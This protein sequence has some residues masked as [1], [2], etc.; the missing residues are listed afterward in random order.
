MKFSERVGAQVV[1]RQIQLEGID[2]ALRNSLW[3]EILQRF[4]APSPHW[5]RAIEFLGRYLFKIPVD[6]LPEADAT[7]HRW[8]RERFF[9]ATWYEAY[10]I[11]EV[12]VL[13]VDT[14]CRPQERA[15]LAYYS[16]QRD[17]FL[18][19]TNFILERELSGYRFVQGTL[20]P[21]SD[22]AEVLAIE[23]AAQ[24]AAKAGLRGAHE[25]IATAL[26]LL[27]RK[28]EPDYRNSIKESISAVEAVVTS[29][30]GGKANGVDDA[31]E[32]LAAKTEVHG[33]L[34]AAIKKLYGYSSDAEGIRHA[35]LDQANVGFDEA[36]FMLVACAAFVN[37]FVS[38]ASKAGLLK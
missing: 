26:A 36:K 17:H 6:D 14:I 20:V 16:D 28:P 9:G 24:A 11:V 5:G 8:L 13:S 27:G 19:T 32:A 35:I 12:L 30:S 34:K 2:E 31:V 18:A 15:L 1:P 21:I 10:D 23:Q 33:A 4:G 3:N 29:V 38:K 25:H 37:F 22:P 7:A